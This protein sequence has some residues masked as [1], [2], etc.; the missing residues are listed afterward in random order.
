MI[1]S[2]VKISDFQFRNYGRV[3]TSVTR[4]IRGFSKKRTFLLLMWIYLSPD[5]IQVEKY[6]VHI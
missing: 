4:S 1:L 3:Q 5:V 2:F 6:R